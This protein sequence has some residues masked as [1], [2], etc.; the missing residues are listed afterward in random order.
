MADS[1]DLG[2]VGD[3]ELLLRRIPE[4]MN[5]YNPGTGF[6]D[7]AALTPNKNDTS[8]L[9]LG[10]EVF[11]APQQEAAKGRAGKRYYVAVLRASD[12]RA[13]GANVHPWPIVGDLGHAEISNLTYDAR[14]TDESLKLIQALRSAVIRVEGPFDG[15]TVH[16]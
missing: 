9:S 12:V 2:F 8:G 14:K 1:D 11:D 4:S 15:R 13:A 10:R 6:I 5:W 7:P 16:D 3:D